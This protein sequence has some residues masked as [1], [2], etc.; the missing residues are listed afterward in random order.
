MTTVGSAK[1]TFE[2]DASGVSDELQ[3]QLDVALRKIDGILD[4]MA[5]NVEQGARRAGSAV[6]GHISDGAEQA[7]AAVR[8]VG[9]D[10]FAT[11]E[12][13]AATV[14]ARVADDFTEAA[15]RA[16]S[17]LGGVDG[18]GFYGATA[19]ASSAAS[20]VASRFIEEAGRADSALKGIDGDGFASATSSSS[21]AAGA[22]RDVMQQAAGAMR[23]VMQ[24]A[25]SDAAGAWNSAADEISS[26]WG[27][28]DER[29][30]QTAG[31]GGSGMLGKVAGAGGAFM[32]L[33]GATNVAMSAF[34]KST[35]IEDTTAVLEVLM[36][37]ADEANVLMDEL[38]ASNWV[39]PIPFDMWADA[40][41]TL[42]AFGMDADDVSGTVTALGEAGAAS[43]DG[44]EGLQRLSRAFG[45]A[46]ATGVVQGDTLNQLAE[47]GVPALDI[48]GNHYG[49]TAEEM[50]KMASEGLP[51]EEAI[52]VLTE[53]IMEGTDGVAGRTAAFSGTMEELAG[54]TSG[55]MGN[56]GSAFTN[57]T[58]TA[59][60]PLL[61]G[62]KD[63]AE[64]LT[65]A[66]YSFQDF[67]KW[68]QAGGP[69][70]KLLGTIV[71]IVA[72][73]IMTF[74]LP[75]FVHARVQGMRAALSNVKAWFL[76][77]TE[78]LKATVTTVKNIGTMI[79]RWVTLGAQALVQGARV[80]AGWVLAMGPVGWII[81]AVAGVVAA[82]VGVW[83]RTEHFGEFWGNVWQGIKDAVGSAVE[84]RKS[85]V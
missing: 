73:A 22:M 83:S 66:L 7:D 56:L 67:I 78:A 43:G 50:K 64:W 71:G 23:D 33:A 63:F 10:A 21:R 46:L 45:Q 80:A 84:D 47:A 42:V 26:A 70:V 40:G 16:D 41:K 52:A 32:G 34:D 82:I 68:L 24:Q 30:A 51:A 85:V 28:V 1:I 13:A 75:A 60:E 44:A 38:I 48:L 76:V 35:S 12:Q 29:V 72:G 54:T 2:A 31:G 55:V 53:G 20:S 8:G 81:A 79:G 14:G 77:R 39:T 37:S 59:I 65:G 27:R 4:T 18:G 6:G 58:A 19:G 74:L 5:G 61:A 57:V 69:Q 9:G 36:G 3:A 15:D 25:A 11:V 62:L 17:A 49:K